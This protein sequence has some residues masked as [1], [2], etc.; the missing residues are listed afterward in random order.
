M[1]VAKTLHVE[2]L[3]V[4]SKGCRFSVTKI[5][6]KDSVQEIDSWSSAKKEKNS[7]SWASGV[8]CSKRSAK[9]AV[10][11]RACFSETPRPW[12]MD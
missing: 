6:K 12:T 4:F 9:L 8:S 7:S 3:H 11:R 1:V 2:A 10:A 5:L